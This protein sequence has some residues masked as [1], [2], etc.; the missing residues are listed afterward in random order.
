[1]NTRN[2]RFRSNRVRDI[3]ALFH[4]ELDPQYGQGEVRVFC[5]MLFEAFLG[6]D[7]VQSLCAPLQTTHKPL[8]PAMS[9]ALENMSE[10]V[11]MMVEAK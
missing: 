7:R 2:L 5:D 9:E 8:P 6:W 1:M 10:E 3:I 11:M 4:E